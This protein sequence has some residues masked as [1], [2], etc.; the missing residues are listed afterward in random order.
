MEK[1]NSFN[2]CFKSE[3]IYYVNVS[4]LLIPDYL[5]MIN[6]KNI[7]TLLSSNVKTYTYNDELKWVEKK[8]ENK[9]LIFSMIERQTQK[10]I[11]NIELTNVNEKSAEIGIVITEVFRENI[12]VR[13]P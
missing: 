13:K 4:K 7:A 2:I 5:I 11:G 9:S 6:N 12:T 8:L 3:N 1:I 10:F